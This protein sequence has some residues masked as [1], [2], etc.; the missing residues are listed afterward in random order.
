MS[1]I[2][3]VARLARVSIS[4]VSNVLN[5]RTRQMSEET[6]VRVQHAVKELGYR[7]NRAAR[8]L[9]TGQTMMLGLLVPSLG[10]PSYGMLAREIENESWSRHGYRIIV[11]NTYREPKRE[12]AFLDDMVSQGVRGVIIIS[13]LADEAH[14]EAP[15]RRGLVAVSYDS[16]TRGTS[17][18]DYVSADNAAGTRLAVEHLV[19]KG[20]RTIAF[21]TPEIWTFSRAQKRKG[22][23]E[24]VAAAGIAGIVIE[25]A[26]ASSYADAEMAELGQGLAGR[27]ADHPDR[28]TAAIAIND[29]M[30]IGLIAGLRERGLDLP[31]DMSIVGMDGISLGAFTAPPLTT[32]KL[33]LEQLASVIV[34]RIML[35][36]R[37]PETLPAEFTYLPTM[38]ERGSVAGASAA[39]P[40]RGSLRPHKARATAIES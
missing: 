34:D 25:G 15:V 36:L 33:P 7:P 13:S 8:Q 20:H 40:P 37:H 3:D 12:R 6:L 1:T 39:N 5:G 28:P 18:L 21:L 17:Q 32:V 16:Q 14:I 22:F 31:R 27:L 11:G 38:L 26:V 35:R 4:T 29:M 9:K 24:T 10:N 23:L 19:A 2:N 30:A